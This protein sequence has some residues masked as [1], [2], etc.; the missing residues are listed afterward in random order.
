M[1]IQQSKVQIYNKIY[2]VLLE[3]IKTWKE[4]FYKSSN[5]LNSWLKQ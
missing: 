2:Q 1:K 4:K 5:K 3:T